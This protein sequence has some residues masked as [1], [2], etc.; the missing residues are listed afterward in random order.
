MRPTNKERR[1]ECFKN[2]AQDMPSHRLDNRVKRAREERLEYLGCPLEN[3]PHPEEP[4]LRLL[5]LVP[6]THCQP[7]KGVGE[8]ASLHPPNQLL[9]DTD[10]R[11]RSSANDNTSQVPVDVKFIRVVCPS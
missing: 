9:L 2:I 10:A 3:T 8:V 11:V 4:Q 7:R 5:V 6:S 1:V